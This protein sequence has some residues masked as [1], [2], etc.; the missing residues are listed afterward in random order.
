MI[1]VSPAQLETIKMILHKHVPDCEVRVFGSRSSSKAKRYS[2]LDLA[3]LGKEKL[4]L[5]LLYDL[6]EDFEVSNLPFRVDVLDWHRT[7]Q[8][9]RKIIEKNFETINLSF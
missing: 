1:D 9:F 6:K 5:K 2:D 4:P 8:E 3:I 7:S